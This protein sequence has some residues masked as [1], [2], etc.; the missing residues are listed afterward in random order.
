MKTIQDALQGY[1]ETKLTKPTI[2]DAANFKPESARKKTVRRPKTD[3]IPAIPKPPV[4]MIGEDIRRQAQARNNIL[5][6]D[7]YLERGRYSAEEIDEA[8]GSFAQACLELKIINPDNLDDYPHIV[9][10]IKAVASENGGTVTP[11]LYRENG[12]FSLDGIDKKYGF[13]QILVKE[14][15]RARTLLYPTY[16]VKKHARHNKFTWLNTH[17][18]VFWS[19]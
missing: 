8:Y 19:A 7:R 5:T 4:W 6:L 9:A 11:E 2:K 14:G 1:C 3:K 18:K 13:N 12:I 16:P 17:D 10:D 15:L